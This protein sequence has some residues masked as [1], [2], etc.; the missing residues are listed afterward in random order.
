MSANT[1]SIYYVNS[2][3]SSSA[4]NVISGTACSNLVLSGQGMDFQVPFNFTANTASYSRT[5]NG[6]DV[7]ILPFQANIPSGVTAYMMSPG[8]GN[9]T[10]TAISNG[11]IPA[12]TPVIINATGNITF[13]G[14]GNVSTPKAITINQMNGA[15]QS[16]KV[17]ANAYVLKTEN[18]VTGFYKVTAGSEP[19]IGSFKAY[20]T[21]ENTYSANVLPL[22][23]GTLS[24][25]NIFAEAKKEQVKIYPNPVKADLFIDS[26]SAEAI[27]A[28]F[29]GR[30]SIIRSGLK[31]NS[32]K[33][34]INV[35]DFPAGIYF[36]EVTQ[37]NSTVVKQKFVK[38]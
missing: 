37:K 7:L 27:A 32:G 20:L 25:R 23:F 24:V 31:I 36:V 2:N 26:D 16:I 3:V 17:P 12:N 13:N 11:I 9:I 22:S 34:H 1:N 28:I 8:A 6:Y 15:Y 29:D 33:N 19:A 38:E 35:A 10:C 14:S 4:N 18:G 21:E 5:F 30:G